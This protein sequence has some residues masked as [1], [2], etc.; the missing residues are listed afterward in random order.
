MTTDENKGL[1][2]RFIT[3]VFERGRPEAAVTGDGTLVI[4]QWL[5]T[6]RA[7]GPDDA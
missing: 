3:E 5:W 1:V 6:P 4:D 7:T 2:R